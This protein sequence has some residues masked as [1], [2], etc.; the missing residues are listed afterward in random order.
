MQVPKQ[1]ERVCRNWPDLLPPEAFSRELRHERLRAQR[2]GNPFAVVLFRP[3]SADA[4][5]GLIAAIFAVV[6]ESDRKGLVFANEAWRVAVLLDDTDRSGAERI[7][8]DVRAQ[9]P[10]QHA[11]YETDVWVFPDDWSHGEAVDETTQA[12][13]AEGAGRPSDEWLRR[14][15]LPS[16]LPL[17]KRALDVGVS[18]ATLLLLSPV[19]LAVAVW[20]RVV[21]PGPILFTQTR[22]GYLGKP[23]TVFKFRTMRVNA[24]TSQ[25]RAHL[26]RLVNAEDT[27]EEA[28]MLKLENDPQ[29]IPGGR[30]LRK[31]AVDELPQLLNVLRG[32]MSLVGPRPPI[33]YEVAEYAYWHGGR[34]DA[35]PGM[36]GLWQVSGKNNL[37]FRE[38]V[39]LDIRY[40]QRRSLWLDV[41]I[42]LMTPKAI[43]DQVRGRGVKA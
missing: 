18:G 9:L 3:H 22:V 13:P 14:S 35:V 38:M 11:A 39:R 10:A 17:W 37:S 21:S 31:T 33:P 15:G 20:V 43:L 40:A 19:L 28:A 2:G 8:R 1:L 26:A 4:Q 36:T 41:R 23:F 27:G 42:I 29:I 34:F 5:A 30:L 32:D 25:H 6:R 24:D 12:Q 16:P 7:L